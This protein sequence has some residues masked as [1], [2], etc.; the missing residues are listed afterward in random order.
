METGSDRGLSTAAVPVHKT[1]SR[2]VHNPDRPPE[3]PNAPPRAPAREYDPAS[4]QSQVHNPDSSPKSLTDWLRP[5]LSGF[6]PPDIVR[7]DR[8][9]LRKLW[10][11][12]ARGAYTAE[13]GLPRRAGQFYSFAA[14]AVIGVLYF[15]AWIIERPSRLIAAGVLAALVFFE[16]VSAWVTSL[17]T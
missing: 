13:S 14:S 17:V 1:H 9:S 10:A 6:T 2:T 15:L 3:P 4:A 8:P 12:G 7:H 11:Y 16:E 5:F